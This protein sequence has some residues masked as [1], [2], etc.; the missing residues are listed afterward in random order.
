MLGIDSGIYPYGT[1]SNPT[2]GG[3]STGSGIA[4]NKI[5]EV[6]GVIKAYTSRVG[7]GPLPTE[8]TGDI[9]KRIRDKGGEY[10]TTTGR[11]R[12]IGWI[13][14]VALR[15]AHEVNGFTGLAFTRIDTL[16][17]VSPLKLCVAY[18]LDGKRIA[19]M[20]VSAEEL[21]R[22]K[23]VY[24]ELPGW[25]DLKP[26]EWRKIAIR[27]LFAIPNEARNYLKM[28]SESLKVPIYMVSVGAG[29]ED[30]I[31]IEDVFAK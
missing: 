3:A 24:E 26:G 16:A 17:G 9:A 22:C 12:R 28:V 10:G 18:E 14:L 8:I 30:T 15:H 23:P 27:G 5:G 7:E 19:R 31:T 21:A 13:D 29:R 6:I 11:P 4:P 20:P 2:S 25:D 1:S